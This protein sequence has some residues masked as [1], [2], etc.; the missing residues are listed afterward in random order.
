MPNKSS[1]ETRA[2][3]EPAWQEGR[4][5]SEQEAALREVA[6]HVPHWYGWDPG[7]KIPKG[8]SGPGDTSNPEKAMSFEDALVE[9]QRQGWGGISALMT[10]ASADLVGVDVD[11]CLIEGAPSDLAREVLARFAG[12][13]IE[14]SPSRTGLRVFCFG[15]VPEG[16]PTKKALG[17]GAGIEVYPGGSK[18]HLR[19]TGAVIGGTGDAVAT[20]QSGIDW[21]VG[22]MRSCAVPDN[23]SRG[24]KGLHRVGDLT[25]DQMLE[26]LAKLRPERSVAQVVDSLRTYGAEK[27]RS[28]VAAL[29]RGDLSTW[30]G[31]WSVADKFAACEAI[32][33]GA[34]S[35]DEVVEVWHSTPLG[36]RPKERQPQKNRRED[37][38]QST[39]E[40]AAQ[41]VLMDLRGKASGAGTA[42]ERQ[43]L[44]LPGDLMQALGRS[45]DVLVYGKGGRLANEAG[46]AVVLFR[47]CPTLRGLLGFNELAQVPQRL[48]SWQVFDREAASVPGPL[49]DDDVTRAAMYFE[50]AWGMRL[51]RKD[52]MR[53]LEAAARDASFDPLADALRS[54]EW[55]G[56]PRIDS[57]LTKW[58]MVDDTGCADYVRAVSAR[59]MIGA[60]ARALNPGCKFD[61]VL[62]VEGEGG[63]GK[64]TMFQV[65]ADAV[66]PGLFTD[67]VHDVSSTASLVEST[68][69]RWIVE[70][71]ELAGVRRAAD[72]EA[73][74][75][76]LTRTED[77]HR[78]PYDVLPR[79][80]P[81][82]FVFVA[83]TNRSEYLNDPS[84]ALLR[85]FWSV[86]T[87]ATEA[88]PIDLDE[89][90][91][92]APQLWAEAVDRFHRGEIW[93]ISAADGPAYTQWTSS[94]EQR[95]EDG[96]F[97][98]EALDYLSRWELDWVAGDQRGRELRVIA[99]AVGDLRTIEGDQSSRSRLAETLRGLGLKCV[100][101]GGGKKRW[102]L[103][104]EARR[105]ALLYREA[106][107]QGG[108]ATAEV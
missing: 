38:L 101:A 65:L 9:M 12:T 44:K 70:I 16:A 33:R 82:R 47:N 108:K 76:A 2:N 67:G 24:D 27:P 64:S 92:V 59:F 19:M 4:Y 48:A 54:L 95:R 98:E 102:V 11:H 25:L 77:S 21:L 26:E 49:T 83:T 53:A 52:L 1:N 29:L 17:D 104:P 7:R 93:H 6:Q 63:G 56:M 100:R 107:L 34:G 14:I 39:V 99:E 85:R 5:T 69:G 66:A 36:K 105:R 23:A 10:T 88:A 40:S 81:R 97:H 61:T 3:L 103:T 74:K 68:G 45:G 13:Y 62:A 58:A 90:A 41:A 55:D 37:Y 60:V 43:S 84:G 86:R 78:R 89:L 79:A 31:D 71:A 72:I 22:V 20:C 28:K 96:A 42:S 73:L 94:R 75:A 46:N 35:F 87:R 80:V 18:R 30:N 51:D 106:E 57:W 15:K 91:K 8:R 50:R 32:R